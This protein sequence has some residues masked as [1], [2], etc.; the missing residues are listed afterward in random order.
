MTAND[1]G[2]QEGRV[3]IGTKQTMKAVELGEAVEV[4]VAQDADPRLVSRIVQLCGQRG[5]KLTHVD[6]MKNLGRACGIEVGAA[7][8]AVVEE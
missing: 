2:L 4:F 5:V 7:M 3:R 6:T 8:A 1:N